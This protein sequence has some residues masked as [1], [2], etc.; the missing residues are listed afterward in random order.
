MAKANNNQYTKGRPAP[1]PITEADRIDFAYKRIIDYKPR[2]EVIK[3]VME[4]FELVEH[5]AIR[6]Y[7]IAMKRIVDETEVDEATKK[8]IYIRGLVRIRDLGLLRDNLNVAIKAHQEIGRV[9]NLIQSEVIDPSHDHLTED[10]KRQRLIELH[11]KYGDKLK[12]L[13]SIDI[14]NELKDD[15]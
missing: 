11:Q 8:K 12:E 6:L 14:D 13:K 15:N 2:S 10:R 7:D 4:Q 3:L 5:N 1:V 9:E